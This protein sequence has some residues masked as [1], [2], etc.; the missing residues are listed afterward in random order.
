MESDKAIKFNGK[1][2][3]LIKKVFRNGKSKPENEYDVLKLY[4]QLVKNVC[5][6]D[7]ITTI[8]TTTKR[9]GDKKTYQLNE[10]IVKYS[11]ML[12]AHK[13]HNNFNNGSSGGHCGAPWAPK[14]RCGVSLWGLRGVTVGSS[15][16]PWAPCVLF[17]LCKDSPL[18]IKTQMLMKKRILS[19]PP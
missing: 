15:W 1:Q 2:F 19:D 7:I 9:K 10:A 13:N 5:G 16:A 6:N 12:H 17:F 14:G 3:K 8:D 11:L 4:V 18:S